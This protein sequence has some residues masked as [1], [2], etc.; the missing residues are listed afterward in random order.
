MGFLLW[1]VRDLLAT[2]T[3][4]AEKVQRTILALLLGSILALFVAVT[5]QWQVW[6]NLAGWVTVSIFLLLLTLDMR[7]F[8]ATK[9]F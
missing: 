8:L 1:A 3:I 4:P 2:G 7:Y 6:V 5:Q 9:K